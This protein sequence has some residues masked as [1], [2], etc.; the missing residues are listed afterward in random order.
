MYRAIRGTYIYACD[1]NLRNYLKKHISTFVS[2]NEIININTE[3]RI[4]PI[5]DVK[6]YINAVPLLDIYAAASNFSTLQVQAEYHNY[7][8]V[9]L[10]MTFSAREGYF[11][12]K[13]LGESMNKVIAN[14][15]MCLFKADSGG[16][17]NGKIVLVEHYDFQDSDFGS[18]YTVKE[19]HSEKEASEEGW[20][21]KSIT[22][23]PKSY[24]SNYN[25]IVLSG[26]ELEHLKVV[27]IFIDIIG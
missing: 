15:S 7:T 24:D 2:K 21:H 19:Y 14:G 18:G 17:R 22:L 27:G 26:E 13:I 11:V 4:L 9:E 8:W 16:S 20:M 23:T 25:D 12:C 3:L 10:P 1:S 6:P 5:E